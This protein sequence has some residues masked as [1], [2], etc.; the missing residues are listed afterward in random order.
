MVIFLV[1][2]IIRED[3]MVQ[4]IDCNTVSSLILIKSLSTIEDLKEKL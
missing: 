3:Y 4:I 1:N 2:N